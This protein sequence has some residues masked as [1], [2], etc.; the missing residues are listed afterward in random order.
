MEDNRLAKIAKNGKPEIPR[1]LGG[2]QNVRTR[3]EHQHHRRTGI[4][5]EI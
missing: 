1:S 5:D 2:L 3:V 4:P